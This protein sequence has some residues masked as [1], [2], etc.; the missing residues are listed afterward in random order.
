MTDGQ[1]DGAREI[2]GIS[3]VVTDIIPP[4]T[5]SDATGQ[6]QHPNSG[7][8]LTHLS[9]PFRLSLS[10]SLSLSSTSSFIVHRAASTPYP[11][12]SRSSTRIRINLY[13]DLSPP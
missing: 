2:F 13:T 10:L 4:R 12:I 1:K 6:V 5:T 8:Y 11:T 7:K 9:S 3:I